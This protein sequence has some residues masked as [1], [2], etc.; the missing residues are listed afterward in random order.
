MTNAIE[1]SKRE[2]YQRIA[3]IRKCAQ[4]RGNASQEYDY[5]VSDR[6]VGVMEEALESY[7]ELLR[8]AMV[9]VNESTVSCAQHS[10]EAFL[11][12]ERRVET[13]SAE[14]EALHKTARKRFEDIQGLEAVNKDLI[15]QLASM[16]EKRDALRN[17]AQA[18]TH[19]CGVSHSV[20]GTSGQSSGENVSF[21]NLDGKTAAI[22]GALVDAQRVMTDYLVPDGIRAKDAIGKMIPIL[23]S[24]KLYVAMRGFEHPSGGYAAWFLSNTQCMHGFPSGEQCVFCGVGK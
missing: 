1:Q 3:D 8:Q 21:A 24:E 4:P 16:T 5:L 19:A 6:I 18:S 7:L 12:L 10:A 17:S 2:M 14:L 23:D 15:E 13:L 11:G 20:G 22:L 9:T